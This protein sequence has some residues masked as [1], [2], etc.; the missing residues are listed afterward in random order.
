MAHFLVTDGIQAKLAAQKSG[1]YGAT[2]VAQQAGSA[3]ANAI[4]TAVN[5]LIT[6]SAA[7]ATLNNAIRT[8]LVNE[9]L[10]KGSA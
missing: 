8:A 2:P 1:F 10:I 7:N 4:V 5:S 3:Q 6:Q 9:G